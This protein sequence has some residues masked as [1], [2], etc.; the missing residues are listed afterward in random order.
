VP[1]AIILGRCI[2]PAQGGGGDERQKRVASDVQPSP[3]HT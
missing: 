3:C 1:G 2:R